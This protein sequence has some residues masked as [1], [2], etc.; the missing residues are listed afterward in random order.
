MTD[1]EKAVIIEVLCGQA[2]ADHLGDVR[3]EEEKLWKLLGAPRLHYSHPAHNSDSPF[4]VT[5]A[6]LESAGYSLPSY[7]QGP[8]DE[9]DED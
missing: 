1:D 5:R 9:D 7:L 4:R 6:R 8:D 3:D 2:L